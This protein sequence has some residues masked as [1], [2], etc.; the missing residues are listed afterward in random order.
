MLDKIMG[1]LDYRHS[2]YEFMRKIGWV[3][4]ANIL[5]LVTS[6]P[7]FTIGASLTALYSVMFKLVQERKFKLVKDY[8]VSFIR[9]FS[10]ATCIWIV[11]LIVGV[12]CYVDI[13]FFVGMLKSFGV[14]GYLMLAVAIAV[15]F[16]FLLYMLAV[17]PILAEFEGSVKDTITV[18]KFV[19]KR[20][21][22]RCIHAVI[23]AILV[24][25]FTVVIIINAW[26]IFIYFPFISFGLTAFILAYIFDSVLRPYYEEDEELEEYDGNEE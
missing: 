6:I 17:F 22:K 8:F 2:F 13:S 18:L 1:I 7:I 10:S 25:G 16:A 24:M 11:C 12:I 26:F 19:V 3:F 14:I 21:L 4:L 9:N 5:F 20:N 23:A 15:T